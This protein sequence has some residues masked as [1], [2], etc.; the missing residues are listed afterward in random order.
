MPSACAGVT[1]VP[2]YTRS[3]MHPV[4]D[5]SRIFAILR[6]CVHPIAGTKTL[7]RMYH[8]SRPI[9]SLQCWQIPPPRR[10]GWRRQQCGGVCAALP[11]PAGG[12]MVLL[13]DGPQQQRG[14]VRPLPRQPPGCRV[15]GRPRQPGACCCISQCFWA[16]A[17]AANQHNAAW[18]SRLL[19]HSHV[20]APAR[21]QVLS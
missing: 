20:R 5:I 9:T 12:E 11:T 13:C 2:S 10:A 17:A 7:S 4:N 18:R 15:P 16:S 1:A 21:F 19:S 6:N 14:T 8:H 3:A